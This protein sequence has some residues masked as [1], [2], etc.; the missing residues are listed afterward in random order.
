[1]AILA[2]QAAQG[3]VQPPQEEVPVE[4]VPDEEDAAVAQEG[5]PQRPEDIQPEEPT[6][7]EQ[8]EFTKVEL[9]AKRVIHE[10]HEAFRKIVDMLKTGKDNPVPTLAQVALLIFG[11]VDG[12]S[13]QGISE[14]II[15]RAAEVCLDLVIDLAEK[16][17]I[18]QVDEQMAADAMNEL[19]ILAGNQYGFD[20]TGLAAEV[21]K[22]KGGQQTPAE[23][24]TEE[25]APA[26]TQPGATQ[27]PL[28][29]QM[30]QG[31]V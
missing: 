23:P 30:A 20:T 31:V 13:K 3:A 2:E 22:A 12:N 27:P 14:S 6:P 8:D 11:I 7:E 16:A 19:I 5:A 1:M 17:G 21:K 9:A 29:A 18:M 4:Q 15:L 28:A 10:K 26:A 24:P 25:A